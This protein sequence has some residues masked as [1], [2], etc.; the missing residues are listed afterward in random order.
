ML[1]AGK[2]GKSDKV[3]V[4]M[5]RPKSKTEEKKYCKLFSLSQNIKKAIKKV[6][7]KWEKILLS[8]AADI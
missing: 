3:C 4:S 1:F 2:R 5:N 7:N 8:S 6:Y